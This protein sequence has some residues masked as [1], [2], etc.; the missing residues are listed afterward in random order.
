MRMEETYIIPVGASRLES[1]A[2]A[3]A[4]VLEITVTDDVVKR[5][6]T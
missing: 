4:S 5:V 2:S 1:S 6:T 3:L